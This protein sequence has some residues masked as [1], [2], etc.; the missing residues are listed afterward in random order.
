MGA[1]GL[2]EEGAIRIEFMAFEEGDLLVDIGRE[3]LE[4]IARELVEQGDPEPIARTIEEQVQKVEDYTLRYEVPELRGKRL[5]R[6]LVLFELYARLG[7]IPEKR[8][9]KYE[10]AM[11]ELRDIR[12]GKFKDLK[13]EDPPP[14]DMPVGGGEW[15]SEEKF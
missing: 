13:I 14:P 3:E 10:E 4:G 9:E 2:Q 15:G 6:A 11:K 8:R 7:T 1:P 5:V 12:D